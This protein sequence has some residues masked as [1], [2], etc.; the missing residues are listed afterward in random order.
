MKYLFTLVIFTSWTISAYSQCDPYF[1]P[2]F[3]QRTA[4]YNISLKLDAEAK[5][6]EADQKFTWINPSP[7]TVHE[8]RMY[9]YLNAFKNT[10]STFLKGASSNIFGQDI[11]DREEESWGW[12]QINEAKDQSGLDLIP[13]SIY[14]QPDDGNKADET[15]LLIPLQ[16]PILPFDTLILDMQFS[17]KLP[18]TI[19][20]SG[21]SKDNFFH[22]VHWFPKAGV[23]EKNTTGQWAWNCHQFHRRTEFYSDFGSYDVEITAPENLVIGASGCRI[24]ETDNQDGTQTVRYYIDDVIDFGW[25]AYPHFEV[26]EEKWNHVNIR[27]LIP[28]EHCSLAPRYLT[29]VKQ[30]LIYLQGHVGPY[31]YPTITLMDPPLHGLRSGMMEYPTYITAGSFYRMPKGIRTMESLVAHEFAHQYFMAIV[32]SNEKEEPWLDEGLVTYFED[33]IMEHFYGEKTSLFD[34]FGYQ[35]GNKENSRL[36][37][38]TLSNPSIGTIARPGWEIKENYK[39]LIYSKTAS[40]LETMR[41]MLG[42]EMMDTIFHRYYQKW[43]FKHPKGKDFISLITQVIKHEKGDSTANVITS[44]LQQGLFETVYCDFAI[45]ELNSEKIYTGQGFYKQSPNRE[46]VK[47]EFTGSYKSTLRVENLGS[48]KIPVD[49]KLRFEDGST[50]VE[51]W[52]GSGPSKTFI[53]ESTAPLMA[54][55]VDP[56]HKVFI[57]LDFNNNSYTVKPNKT[58]LRKYAIK[59]IYWVQN[60]LQSLSFLM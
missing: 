26:Y 3:S 48:L 39:G 32:A 17:A 21:Y 45:T 38:T 13:Q 52:E 27:L 36:E 60:S 42:Q 43:K 12:I 15:V 47:S 54:A 35:I 44:F 41:R 25:V 8:I 30:S 16:N 33:C 46:Y 2:P 53:F 24:A 28:P 14:I 59:A 55:H 10:E 34:L 50:K 23:F 4:N 20:R 57:D 1:D 40:L 7:D 29:A 5:I 18:K 6:I 58:S 51:H 11:R 19:V 49:I 31:P 9:M 37:Y 22:F 56:D